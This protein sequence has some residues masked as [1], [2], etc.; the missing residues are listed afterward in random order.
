MRPATQAGELSNLFK[1]AGFEQISE[2]L[3][4]IR[5]DF[6]SFENYWDPLIGGQGTLA[7]FLSNLPDHTR[8]RVQDSVRAAYP[9]DRLDSP[10]SFASTAW[11]V[12]GVAPDE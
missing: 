9:C 4:S 1:A 5:M 11:V 7:E 12:R 8:E 6:T 10:P 2:T 3:L